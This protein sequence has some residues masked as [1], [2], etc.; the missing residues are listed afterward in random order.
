MPKHFLSNDIRMF[1][2]FIIPKSQHM[3]S[4]SIERPSPALVILCL[5]RITVLSAVKFNR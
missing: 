3:Y 1:Q 4:Q 5:C 2:H